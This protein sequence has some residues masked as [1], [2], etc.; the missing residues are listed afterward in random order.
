L[1][2]SRKRRHASKLEKKKK[3]KKNEHWGRKTWSKTIE[4]DVN[5]DV[6]KEGSEKAGWKRK[7]RLPFRRFLSFQ[8][9]S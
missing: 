3:K 9:F 5:G 2:S 4:G 1:C 8:L 7:M 6:V